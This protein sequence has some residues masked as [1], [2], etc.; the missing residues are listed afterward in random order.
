MAAL[1]GMLWL[2][3]AFLLFRQPHQMGSSVQDQNH[4][5]WISRVGMRWA[6]LGML[7]I[8]GAVILG[9]PEFLSPPAVAQSRLIDATILFWWLIACCGFGLRI[10]AIRTL[11]KFFTFQI[12]IRDQHGL[13]R[14]GP[15]RLL[16]HPSYTGY[17]LFLLG[18][19]GASRSWLLFGLC[20]MPALV[21]LLI[22]VR[23]EED[24][25]R[26]HFREDYKA[27]TNQ[28]WALIPWVW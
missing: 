19:C 27:F 13:V 16:R 4:E 26:K 17:L 9:Q 18:V 24:M 6:F 11:G 10:W 21:A 1:L 28:T 22:R 15:Y 14:S 12:G 25:L 2:A 23:N 8:H 7:G 20:W 3:H 5:P